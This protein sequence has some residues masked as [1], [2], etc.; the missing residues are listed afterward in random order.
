MMGTIIPT[1]GGARPRWL[2]AALLHTTASVA[3]GAAVG[4][5]MGT[6]GL[7]VFSLIDLTVRPGLGQQGA[8]AVLLLAALAAG[9]EF[10]LWQVPWPQSTRQVPRRWR[11]V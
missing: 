6:L 5:L 8:L 9:H 7:F 2:I 4:T 3:G 1:V 10:G 11:A